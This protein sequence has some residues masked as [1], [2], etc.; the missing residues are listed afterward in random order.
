MTG[1]ARRSVGSIRER[2]HNVWQISLTVGFDPATGRQKRRA[3][4]IRGTKRQAELELSKMLGGEE[5][6]KLT[7][8][9]CLEEYLADI[10]DTVREYTFVGYER[11]AKKLRES[12]LASLKI[13]QLANKERAIKEYLNNETTA[14]GRQSAYKILR[15]VCNYAKKHHYLNTSPMDYIEEPKPDAREIKTIESKD[16][17]AYLNAVKGTEI[18]AGI[19]INLACGLRRSE[20]CALEWSDIDK[21]GRVSINK[22]LHERKGG[23]LYFDK[24]KTAKST[25]EV[26][27]PLWAKDLLKPLRNRTKYVCEHNGELMHPDYFS[28]QW[29][30]LVKRAGLP[31]IKLKDLRH[32]TGTILAREAGLPI[33]DVQQLLGHTSTRTTERF[34][35]QTS[36]VSAKRTANAWGEFKISGN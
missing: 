1:K 36:E 23:G 19:I 21:D 5:P 8:G 13:S 7:V 29:R 30:R 2:G 3:K 16:I 26:I 22:S 9:Q 15:Q 28:R 32:S 17:E 24:T 18:E 31:A 12:N 34:Y 4:T 6:S 14:G 33:A 25:R 11:N 20:V 27:L 10:K 35:I